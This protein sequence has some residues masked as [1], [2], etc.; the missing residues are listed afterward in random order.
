MSSIIDE[1]KNSYKQGSVLIRLIYINLIV[2]LFIKIFEVFLFLF[3]V[4][5]ESIFNPVL[6]LAVPA[7]I[8]TLLIRPWTIITYMFL[9]QGFLHI[10]FNMLWLYW[11]G[12]I[13]LEYLSQRQLVGVYILGG[14]S[15][16]L[17]YILAF[18][19]F[20]AFQ[21]IMPYSIALGASASVLAVVIAISVYVPDYTIHLLFLGRV[22][23]K[24][25][26]IFSVFLDI[27]SISSGNAGGHIAHLGGAFF[28]YIFIRQLKK[29]KDITIGIN[30]ILDKIVDW[31][32]PKPKIRVEHKRANTDFEY[33]YE[34][35]KMQEEI[36]R[37]LDKIA[38]SGYD[39][40][41]KSEK[42]ILFKMGKNN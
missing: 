41:S 27:L 12:R 35:A 8:Q 14:L 18:N 7:D 1:L 26:A 33:N 38:K 22:K 17:L 23:L 3:S 39:S 32:K 31:F 21:D 34:K 36:D 29:N 9:H 20:P 40:L 15:G 11:L 13:F 4:N 30:R 19:V 24:Y 16:A 28:G 2:F 10:L 37:I 42:D 5:P 25:I 6:W